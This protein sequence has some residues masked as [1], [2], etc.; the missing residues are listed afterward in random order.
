MH[1]TVMNMARCMVFAS[2]LPLSFWGDAVEYA[3]Y[4]LNRSL[5][6]ANPRRQSP[7]EMLTGKP[8]RLDDIVIFGSPCT[9]FR[10][11]RNGSL[12]KRSVQGV[13]LGKSEETKGYRVYV[14]GATAGEA[15][16]SS[17]SMYKTS[18]R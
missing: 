8:P 18:K 15:K 13:I 7:W 6:R 14:R 17:R 4:I 9:A 11:P 5:T 1:R 10:Q 12:G 16:G 3:A 2:G